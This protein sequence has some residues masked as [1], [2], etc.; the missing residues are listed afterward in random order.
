[1]K[2]LVIG[3]AAAGSCFTSNVFAQTT[4]KSQSQTGF[5]VGVHGGYSLPIATQ[6][7]NHLNFSNETE[8]DGGNRFDDILLSL[9]KG[10]NAGIN[11]GYMFNQNLGAE[12]GVDYLFGTKYDAKYRDPSDPDYTFDQYLSAKMVQF[13]PSVVLRTSYDQITPYAKL[14]F[15]IGVGSTIKYEENEHFGSNNYEYE[16]EMKEGVGFGLNGAI[17]L[18]YALNNNMSVF[19]EITAVS[20]NY[21]PKKGYVTQALQNGTDYLPELSVR[22][23]EI[24]FLDDFTDNGSANEPEKQQRQSY[25]FSSIGLNLGLKYRF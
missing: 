21:A 11:I 8:Q 20:M 10:G 14:G 15:V 3:L 24:E 25:P 4:Q 23:K 22:D 13:K 1:M 19:G 9:G 6:N 12:L 2:K 5:Y 18:D 7:I 16:M 17:G